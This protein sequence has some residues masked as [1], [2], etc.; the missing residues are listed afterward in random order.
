MIDERER[1]LVMQSLLVKHVLSETGTDALQVG[2]VV[3]D[4][5]DVLDLLVKELLLQ[6]VSHLSMSNSEE[7]V[8]YTAN[9]LLKLHR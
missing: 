8:N 1:I 2:N 5:P 3:P 4:L 7:L 6:P 9:I